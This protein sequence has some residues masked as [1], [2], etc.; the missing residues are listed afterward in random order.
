MLATRLVGGIEKVH[1]LGG[2]CVSVCFY[3]TRHVTSLP[4]LKN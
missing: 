4:H 3:T 1:C 2:E